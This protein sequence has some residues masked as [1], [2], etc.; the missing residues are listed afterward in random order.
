MCHMRP[1][2]QQ[3]RSS[4]AQQCTHRSQAVGVARGGQNDLR[5]VGRGRKG[6]REKGMEGGRERE[7]ERETNL[8]VHGHVLLVTCIYT[9]SSPAVT[10]SSGGGYQIYKYSTPSFSMYI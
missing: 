7:R 10:D 6:G 1:Q 8:H 4:G 2:D 9:G 5:E 3:L